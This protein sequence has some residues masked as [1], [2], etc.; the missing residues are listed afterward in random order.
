MSLEA[1]AKLALTSYF[2][3][4]QRGY[5]VCRLQYGLGVSAVSLET[6]SIEMSLALLNGAKYCCDTV[7]CGFVPNWDLLRDR[8][9]EAGLHF[10]F[11]LRLRLREV[12]ERGALIA[13]EPANPKTE[14]R[15]VEKARVEEYEIDEADPMWGRAPRP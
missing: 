15:R 3:R 13:V 2:T 6:N 11:P 12:R 14:Y 7:R 8:L 9:A 1:K 5:K 4:D 10:G